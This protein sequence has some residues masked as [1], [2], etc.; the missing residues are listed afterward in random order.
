MM[1]VLSI[2]EEL[3]RVNNTPIKCVALKLEN[4]LPIDEI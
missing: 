1:I 4:S 2:F 3:L